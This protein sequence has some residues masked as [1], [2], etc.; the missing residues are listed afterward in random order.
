MV[1]PLIPP[2][3]KVSAERRE[4]RM[5]ASR[6]EADILRT[7]IRHAQENHTPVELIIL[8]L[9]NCAMHWQNKTVNTKIAKTMREEGRG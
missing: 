2:M 3:E 6:L 1:E 8:A 9:L 4:A 7:V 5:R